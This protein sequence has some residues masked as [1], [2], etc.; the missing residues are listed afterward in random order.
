ML[1]QHHLHHH[2]QHWLFQP[3]MVRKYL[4]KHTDLVRTHHLHYHHHLHLYKILPF[5]NYQKINKI[6]QTPCTICFHSSH[7]HT[8]P[9]CVIYIHQVQSN[10]NQH[11]VPR[12]EAIKYHNKHHIFPKK[13]QSAK[14]HLH[15]LYI[16]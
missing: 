9:S 10:M 11:R 3:G 8:N 15:K 12:L 16:P 13:L 14:L 1:Y 4:M 5:H 6:H 7:L 2:L